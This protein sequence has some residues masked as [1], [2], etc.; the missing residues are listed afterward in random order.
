VERGTAYVI[1]LLVVWTSGAQAAGIFLAAL[2]IILVPISLLSALAL[3]L[4]PIFSELAAE[5]RSQVALLFCLA[6]K[7]ACRR[8][9]CGDPDRMRA[10]LLVRVIFGASMPRAPVRL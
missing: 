7:V 3:G 9:R 10:D 6:L 5:K 4:Y 1:P 8:C 2:K